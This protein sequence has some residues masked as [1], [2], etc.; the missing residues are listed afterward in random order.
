[1]YD[2]GTPG[3]AWLQYHHEMAYLS[4]SIRGIGFCA[5]KA[6][7]DPNDPNRGATFLSHTVK[8]TRDILDTEFG[9]KLKTKRICCL[10]HMTN[11]ENYTSMDGVYNHWQR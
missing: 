2:S 6:I 11:E 5:H 10:R 7:E 4:E 1:V 3:A 8:T 9:Q